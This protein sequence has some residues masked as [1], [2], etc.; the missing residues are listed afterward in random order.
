ML[1]LEEFIVTHKGKQLLCF[2]DAGPLGCD[3]V[4]LGEWFPR[5]RKNV[6]PSS[7]RGQGSILMDNLAL[8]D[9]S[10]MVFVEEY[11]LLGR[12]YAVFSSSLL[13]PPSLTPV[14]SSYY[15]PEHSLKRDQVPYPHKQ[16]AKL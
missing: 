12:F 1:F 13:L 15:I 8:E 9:G 4:A 11:N 7:L 10:T 16:P 2:G 14:S 6:M 5:I 3:A